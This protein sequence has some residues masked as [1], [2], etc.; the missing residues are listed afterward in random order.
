MFTLAHALFM[1][2]TEQA[3]QWQGYTFLRTH[4]TDHGISPPYVNVILFSEGAMTQLD[5]DQTIEGSWLRIPQEGVGQRVSVR[6]TMSDSLV[7]ANVQSSLS[8]NTWYNL[9]VEREFRYTFN[10]PTANY[11]D[12]SGSVLFEFRFDATPD[13]IVE[14]QYVQ[15]ELVKD[16]D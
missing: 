2:R 8:D 13:D 14:S 3:I 16:G 5:G 11:A 6:A 1:G 9:V 4:S 12:A 10:P 7:S 15:I